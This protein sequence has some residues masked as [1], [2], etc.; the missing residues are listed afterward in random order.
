MSLEK[1]RILYFFIGYSTF[2]KKEIDILS[3]NYDVIIFDFAV[4]RSAK[5][6]L[7]LLFL[8]QFFFMK[9]PI[10]SDPM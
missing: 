4:K 9:L 10:F 8:K 7:I 6:M 1:K 2:V 3:K 5:W